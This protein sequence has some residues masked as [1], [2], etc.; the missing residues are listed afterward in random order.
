MLRGYPEYFSKISPPRRNESCTAE[1]RD[2]KEKM[3]NLKK[4]YDSQA[5]DSTSSIEEIRKKLDRS[6][7][8]EDLC[9]VIDSKGNFIL[10]SLDTSSPIPK[11]KFSLTI[12][13]DLSF[14]MTYRDVIPPKKFQHITVV[15]DSVCV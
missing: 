8:S 6:A 2:K 14:Q 11:V 7:I 4:M 1:A 3:M 9:E 10:A 12:H 5:K 13:K 15:K